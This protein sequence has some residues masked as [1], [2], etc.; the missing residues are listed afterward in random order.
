MISAPVGHHCPACVEEGAV[1]GSRR[2]AGRQGGRMR[3]APQGPRRVTLVVG[4]LIATNVVVFILTS[5]HRNLE[6]DYAQIPAN[7]AHG[8][9]YRL[10][11]AAFIHENITH[12]VFNMASL[13][14]MGPPVEEALGPR[15]F[16]AL[17]VLAALGGSILSFL[18]GP[19]FVLG[20]G[21]SGAIFGIFGAWF[22]LARASRSDTGVIVLLIG[23]LLATSFYDPNIDWRAHVGGL[24]TGAAIGAVFAY[25]SNR[26]AAARVALEVAVVAVT[27]SLFV[28]L[29]VVRSAQ[30]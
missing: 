5:T 16:L 9:A 29:V 12:L 21:A 25:A 15:R 6:F 13:V 8:Q 19:V 23:I 26:R 7:V 2:G 24:I 4:I 18:F 1:P 27:L 11:T 20:V 17:Y 10:F 28:G 30:L 22:S 14:V 3:W